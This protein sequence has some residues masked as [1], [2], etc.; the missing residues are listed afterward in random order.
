[1]EETIKGGEQ[2]LYCPQETRN[3]LQHNIPLRV[4]AEHIRK[5]MRQKKNHS[6]GKLYAHERS[7]ERN[8]YYLSIT[9]FHIVDLIS[10]LAFLFFFHFDYQADTVLAAGLDERDDYSSHGIASA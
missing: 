5:Y 10:V 2:N 8:A 7:R 3:R 9:T 1:M 4:A 6:F